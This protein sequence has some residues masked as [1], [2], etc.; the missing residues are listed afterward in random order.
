MTGRASRAPVV[1]SPPSATCRKQSRPFVKDFRLTDEPLEVQSVHK[2][3]RIYA[4]VVLLAAGMLFLVVTL[5]N[6]TPGHE[7]G[8][9]LTAGCLWW[10]LYW[11]FLPRIKLVLRPDS[12]EFVDLSRSLFF[13]YPRY[14]VL[15]QDVLEAR[16]RTIQAGH[17]SAIQTRVKGRVSE[18]PLKTRTFAVTNQDPGYFAFLGYL[19]DRLASS[20]VAGQGLGIDPTHIR[21][22]AGRVLRERRQLVLFFAIA[23]VL[24]VVVAYF[25]RR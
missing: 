11:A 1:P 10:A 6:P 5:M 17:G 22:I 24:L 7:L 15:W 16:S 19:N 18:M 13:I 12:I 23:G 4:V 9:L 14:Q 3:Q 20:P 21:E 8:Y 2:F 25:T